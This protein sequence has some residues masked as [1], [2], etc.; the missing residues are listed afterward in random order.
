MIHSLFGTL[1][2]V[3]PDFFAATTPENIGLA[4]DAIIG[5]PTLAAFRTMH[6]DCLPELTNVNLEKILLL[7]RGVAYNFIH[8]VV[9][10]DVL[11]KR[12][13]FTIF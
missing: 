8:R 3:T 11:R 10:T 6:A 13:E 7:Q 4:I 12:Y 5:I 9:S 1:T 2:S